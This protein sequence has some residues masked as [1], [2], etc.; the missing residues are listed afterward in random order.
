MS[1]RGWI[2]HREHESFDV[3]VYRPCQHQVESEVAPG[4]QPHLS[5]HAEGFLQ[6]DFPTKD[7]AAVLARLIAAHGGMARVIDAAYREPRVTLEQA[8]P[9]AEKELEAL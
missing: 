8:W 2:N 5:Q 7:E 1:S 4:L 6:L 9:L 3:Y